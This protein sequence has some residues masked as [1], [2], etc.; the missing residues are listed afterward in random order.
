MAFEK[1]SKSGIGAAALAFI[2][3][4][5]IGFAPAPTTQLPTVTVHHNPT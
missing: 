2:T 1:V 3:I 4:A 5:S